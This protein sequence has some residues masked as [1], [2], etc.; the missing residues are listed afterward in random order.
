MRVEIW[1][2]GYLRRPRY[3][4][5]RRVGARRTGGRCPLPSQHACWLIGSE[6]GPGGP[7]TG[8]ADFSPAAR[9]A[10]PVLDATHPTGGTVSPG[11]E[12][13]RVWRGTS[14]RASKYPD[15]RRIDSACL[16]PARAEFGVDALA[17]IF[18]GKWAKPT[19]P[20]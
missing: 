3:G 16:R 7:Q 15:R 4:A 13:L 6:L 20:Q 8:G 9:T 5:A 11:S 18:W 10:R 17:W 1:V 12:M 2:L 19:R 14:G